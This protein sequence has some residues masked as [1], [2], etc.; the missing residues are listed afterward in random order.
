MEGFTKKTTWRAE[1]KDQEGSWEPELWLVF[2]NI[3]PKVQSLS[4]EV[5]NLPSHPNHLSL[6]ACLP[7]RPLLLYIHLQPSPPSPLNLPNLKKTSQI[8]NTCSKI[9]NI[10][11]SPYTQVNSEIMLHEKSSTHLCLNSRIKRFTSLQSLPA[12]LFAWLKLWISSFRSRIHTSS[13][14]IP[15]PS[16]P[17]SN[18]PPTPAQHTLLP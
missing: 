10:P 9:P 3:S 7:P 15:S 4:G 5:G 14:S 6:S 18:H 2:P 12:F 17:T 1:D 16:L 11:T 8:P 13:L